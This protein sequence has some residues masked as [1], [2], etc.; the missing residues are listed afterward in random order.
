MTDQERLKTY[1][2]EQLWEA[3]TEE[4]YKR[5]QL[6]TTIKALSRSEAAARFD[7]KV[8]EEKYLREHI[9]N[10]VA[11]VGDMDAALN[12]FFAHPM[13]KVMWTKGEGYLCYTV[14]PERVFIWF[15]WGNHDRYRD[16]IMSWR[17]AVQAIRKVYGLPIQYTGVNNVLTN[18]SKEL[19]KGLW[20]ICFNDKNQI[21][22]RS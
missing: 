12:G 21:V 20:E 3:F 4:H 18:H 6:E 17:T 5:K 13:R 22:R 15:A 9:R 1:T 19:S 14:E 11:I 2:K 7:A 10:N 16:E 8:F